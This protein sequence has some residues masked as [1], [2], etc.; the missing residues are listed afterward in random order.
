MVKPVAP[1]TIKN[2]LAF[3]ISTSDEFPLVSYQALSFDDIEAFSKAPSP[4]YWLLW[5]GVL[6]MVVNS[7]VDVALTMAPSLFSKQSCLELVNDV[8]LSPCRDS[9]PSF[10]P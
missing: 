2:G 10:E 1:A 6:V 4:R 5:P 3:G 7:L 8:C 9:S